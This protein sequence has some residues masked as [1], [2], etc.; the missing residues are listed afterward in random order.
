MW[1]SK[2]SSFL[3]N[4]GYKQSKYDYSLFVKRFQWCITVIL[5]YV[6]DVI[7]GGNEES[8]ITN[9]KQL[10]DNSFRIKDLG[11]LRYFFGI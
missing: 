1:Y 2:L 4:I 11:V 9:V 5:V 3:I 6:D 8:E 10:L 7:I